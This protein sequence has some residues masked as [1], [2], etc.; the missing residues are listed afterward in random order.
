MADLLTFEN[1]GNL[2]MLC[3]LQAVL[4]F[5]NLLYIS[6]E[7]QRAP[8]AHQRAVRFWG[9]IIAVALR[10][11]LLFTM[12]RLIDALSEPFL[13][14]DVPGVISGGVNFATCVFLLGGIF[15]IYTAVKEISHMLSIEHLNT[16][17]DNKSGKSAVQVVLL[18]VFMNLIFS[19]D[20]VLSALAITDVFPV[21]ATA[22]LLSG[23]AMLLLADGVTRFL[24]KNR[25]YEVLG[26]FI[27]LIVGVV[28]LGEAG[29]A[30]AHA[31]HDD[32]LALHLFGY[33][34][35]PMSKTTFYFSVVVL[36]IV[37]II[38]SRYSRKLARERKA[39][40]PH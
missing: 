27:L 36:F 9:I 21:L 1:L 7:S 34:L 24:E 40:T 16:D 2:L 17:V 13:I 4:G 11:I 35:V 5:D 39:G 6:I 31:A 12:I 23:L 33:E 29:Q 32:S 25:M 10:V 3:F 18:I 19:F 8:V 26:L 37:E 30:A 14:L 28:L 22:I 15:I 38:Q 20:S